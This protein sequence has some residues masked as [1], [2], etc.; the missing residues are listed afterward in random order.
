[1]RPRVS[2]FEDAF[3]MLIP[4]LDTF[5]IYRVEVLAFENNSLWYHPGP[6]MKQ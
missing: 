6:L 4:N 2:G 3:D 1:M 5:S